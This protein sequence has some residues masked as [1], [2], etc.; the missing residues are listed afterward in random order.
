LVIDELSATAGVSPDTFR[1][2]MGSLPTG[3][4]IVTTRDAHGEPRGLTVSSCTSVSL[5]PPLLLICLVR[6][7]RSRAAILRT[8]SFAV[9]ILEADHEELARRFASPM[10]NKFGELRL[11][12]G[13]SGMPLLADALATA[14]CEIAQTM[15][16]GDHTIIVGRV[17]EGH[18]RE[19]RPL[20]HFRRQFAPWP[21]QCE[22]DRLALSAFLEPFLFS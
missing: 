4:T 11:Y 19:G 20:M 1:R 3:V 15:E 10:E 6:S 9:N 21:D 12:E 8:G 13:L 22:R 18:T 17:V 14:E 5:D 2:I 7:S 16:A